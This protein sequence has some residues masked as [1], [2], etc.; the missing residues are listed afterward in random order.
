M[1]VNVYWASDNNGSAISQP[2]NHGD[3]SNGSETSAQT[4]WIYHDGTNAITNCGF[5]LAQYSGSYT[6]AVSALADYNELLAWGDGGTD[7]AWGG[8]QINMDASG[9]FSSAWPTR[10]TNPVSDLGY[11]FN[12]DSDMGSDTDNAITLAA[13]MK[14]GGGGSDGEIP[15]NPPNG[16]GLDHKFQARIKVP[17]DEDTAGKRQFD[18]VLKYTYTS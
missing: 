12:T 5:Y 10:S 3:V 6:G 4:I 18:L 13:E 15:A 9:G 8:Y 1:A 11:N 16:Y 7:D 14:G 17:A 2:L